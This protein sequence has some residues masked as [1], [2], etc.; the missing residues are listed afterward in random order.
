MSAPVIIG[1]ANYS[2]DALD[3][4]KFSGQF[5]PFL[6]DKT[7]DA[8]AFPAGMALATVDKWFHRSR[9][10]SLSTDAKVSGGGGSVAFVQGDQAP[11]ACDAAGTAMAN[12]KDHAAVGAA[13]LCNAVADI[14]PAAGYTISGLLAI[15]LFRATGYAAPAIYYDHTNYFPAL[16]IGANLSLDNGTNAAQLVLSSDP[17][18][19]SP[20]T[21]SIAATID[22]ETVTL[23]YKFTS[24]GTGSMTLTH[25]DLTISS[26]WPYPAKDG[27]P[28]YDTTTGL[29]L[30]DPRVDILPH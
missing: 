30:Q 16:Q 12:E 11:G 3:S 6:L 4:S 7:L 26:Y 17:G 25:F 13:V 18:T 20:P 23:Y 15:A 14:V 27:S 28:I 22:T 24:S 9:I 1:F 5:T 10:W 29:Q 2:G 8:G 21:G 19:F